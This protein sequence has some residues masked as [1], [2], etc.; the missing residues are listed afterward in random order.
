[1]RT[2]LFKWIDT[3]VKVNE[4]IFKFFKVILDSCRFQK[5]PRL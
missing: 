5:S 2:E 3:D 4:E 1:M